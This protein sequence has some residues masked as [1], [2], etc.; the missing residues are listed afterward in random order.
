MDNEKKQ[1]Y[2]NNLKISQVISSFTNSEGWQDIIR[3]ALE[4]KRALFLQEMK[5]AEKLEDFY[6]IKYGVE[7]INSMFELIAFCL[8]QGES[9]VNMLEKEDM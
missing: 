5:T 7:A 4:K 6:R 2:Q 3:P 8:K 9:A 1:D